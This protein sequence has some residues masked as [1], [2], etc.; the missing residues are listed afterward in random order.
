MITHSADGTAVG[1]GCD[2]YCRESVKR[3]SCQEG[4]PSSMHVQAVGS[5]ADEE[6]LKSKLTLKR[7]SMGMCKPSAAGG[8]QLEVF[9]QS[10][11]NR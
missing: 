4:V 2:E 7:D 9:L 8:V 10:L 11:R 1:E 6:F 5:C 3:T